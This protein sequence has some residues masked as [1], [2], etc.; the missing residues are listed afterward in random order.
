[1]LVRD[2]EPVPAGGSTELEPGDEVL[3]ITGGHDADVLRRL[4]ERQSS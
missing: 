4:F 3:V 2:G 1:M